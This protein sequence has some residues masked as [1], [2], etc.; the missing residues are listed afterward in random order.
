MA[1]GTDASVCYC[2]GCGE[3][4]RFLS[5]INMKERYFE[6]IV[7]LEHPRFITQYNPGRR[8][9]FIEKYVRVLRGRSD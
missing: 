3:N 5:N 7:P 1:F 8:D 6:K 2:I 4:F 9:E